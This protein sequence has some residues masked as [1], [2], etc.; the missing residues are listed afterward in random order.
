MSGVGLE[1][2]LGWAWLGLRHPPLVVLADLTT[3]TISL[4]K[5]G[6]EPKRFNYSPRG[7]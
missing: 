1:P 3:R 7:N 5:P 4:I 2:S 6:S